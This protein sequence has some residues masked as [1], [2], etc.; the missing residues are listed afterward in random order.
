M[1]HGDLNESPLEV[2][3]AFSSEVALPLLRQ[4]VSRG[5]LPDAAA[6]EV[7]STLQDFSSGGKTPRTAQKPLCR[8]REVSV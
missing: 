3:S 4:Q 7:T 1:L 5:A 6:L 8:K 2:L